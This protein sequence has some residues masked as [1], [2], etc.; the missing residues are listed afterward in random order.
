[1]RWTAKLC[2]NELFTARRR[3]S[4]PPAS[5]AAV[6]KSAGACRL[7]RIK[8]KASAVESVEASRQD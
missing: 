6:F 7:L 8:E 2:T 1:M 5:P 3:V 4:T